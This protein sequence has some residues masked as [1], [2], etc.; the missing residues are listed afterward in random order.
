ML[1]RKLYQDLLE[2]ISQGTIYRG[3]VYLNPVGTGQ[4]FIEYAQTLIDG[5]EIPE[6]FM[7]PVNAISA[8]NIDEYKN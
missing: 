1:K 8:E 3:T 6:S 7:V 2:L 4:Q 5:G